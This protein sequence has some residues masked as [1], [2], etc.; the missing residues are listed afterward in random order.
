MED[1]GGNLQL[2]EPPAQGRVGQPPD[3]ILVERRRGRRVQPCA[4]Q[5][6]QAGDPV[7][8]RQGVAQGQRRAP[9]V[10]ADQPP[11]MAPVGTQR[12]QVGNGTGDGLAF[13]D[14]GG[15]AA[16]SLVEAVDGYR[17]S[18]IWASGS[19]LSLMPGP[20]WHRTSGR[21]CPLVWVQSVAAPTGTSSVRVAP[22]CSSIARWPRSRSV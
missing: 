8:M 9:G 6:Q 17:S 1:Q 10:A 14:A 2:A 20:P 16:G 3:P 12:L 7:G 13:A 4:R 15:A 18:T 21:P 11:P 5:V 19:R 22:G